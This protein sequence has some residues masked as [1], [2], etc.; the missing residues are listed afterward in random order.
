MGVEAAGGE[1]PHSKTWHRR[2]VILFV[3]VLIMMGALILQNRD[4]RSLPFDRNIWVAESKGWPDDTRHR[5]AD[6]LLAS[7]TL[8]GK[9]RTEIVALLGE[10]PPTAYFGSFD[11]VYWFGPERG[12]PPIDSE[13]LVMRL[14]ANKHV[15][16]AWI[17]RD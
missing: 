16:E 5:M 12:L 15:S 14:N 2:L 13:W 3:I 6:G 10:P 8:I 1:Q 9:S 17:A 4:R 7:R 11:L